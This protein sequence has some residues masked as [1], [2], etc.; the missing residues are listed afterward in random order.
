MRFSGQG[1]LNW[2]ERKF[3][4]FVRR[5][6]TKVR[7]SQECANLQPFVNNS[8][9]YTGRSHSDLMRNDRSAR[10][11]LENRRHQRVW[12]ETIISGDRCRES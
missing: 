10:R 3:Q 9:E 11:R 8:S 7:S 4:K 1:T 2:I 12:A 5:I 6:V